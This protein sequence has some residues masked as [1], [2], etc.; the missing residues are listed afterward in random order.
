M[1]FA[2][3]LLLAAVAVTATAVEDKCSFGCL[4]VYEPVC[5]S[6]GET[7]SNACYLRLASC[8]SDKEITQSSDGECASTPATS[9][10]PSPKT[11]SSKS[12]SGAESCDFACLDV[13]DPVTDENG[14][15]YSNECYMKL[16]KCRGTS[17]DN[18]KRIENPRISTMGV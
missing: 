1:K 2:I 15:E 5:G 7:Y 18:N 16:A 12:N 10:T 11:S 4:D 14:N 13:Y 8:Q 3:G 6:N 17:G 9:A